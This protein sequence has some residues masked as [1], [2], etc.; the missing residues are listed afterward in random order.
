MPRPTG[1]SQIGKVRSFLRH[2][3]GTY[4]ASTLYSAMI[5]AGFRNIS[6][7]AASRGLVE[8]EANGYAQRIRRGIYHV[9][10]LDA[11]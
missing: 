4:S 9:R 5:L 8:W 7:E 1:T 10:S 6:T 3:P 11:A 2:N